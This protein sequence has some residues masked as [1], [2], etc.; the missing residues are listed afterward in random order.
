MAATITV[1]AGDNLQTAINAAQ[2][3]DTLLL[4]AGATFSGNFILPVK[5]GAAYITITTS[6][7]AGLPGPAARVLPAHAPWLAK[8][9]SPNNGP[10]L[11]TVPG[12]HHWRLVLL[13]FPATHLGYGDIMQIG[14]GSHA[15]NVLSMVPRDF[16]LDRLYVHGDPNVGQKRGIALNAASVTIRN[17]YISDIKA[18]GADTQA[19]GGWNGPGPYTIENNYLEASGELFLLGG[20]DPG[21][22][23]LVATGVVV[24]QNHFFRPMSWRDPILPDPAGVSVTAGAGGTLA[25]GTYTYQVVARKPVGGG[26]VARSAA[27]ATVAAAVGNG[28]SV[29]VRWNAVPGATQYYVYGRTGNSMTQYWTV[30]G[31]SFTDTGLAGQS[32]SVPTTAG[33]RWLV[34][35]L[36]QLKSARQVLVESNVF[37]NNWA[38]GQAGYAIVFTPRNQ[39]GNCTWCVISDVTFT[40][41]I[42]RNTAAAFNI[43]GYDDLAP[44]QQTTRITIIN[45]LVYGVRRSLGGNGW[46]VLMGA[47]PSHVVIDHNTVESDGSSLTYVSGGTAAA[48]QRVASFQFTNNAARHGDYGING[49]NFGYGNAIIAN[50]FPGGIIRGNWLQGGTAAR[51]PADNYFAGTF[52]DAFVDASGGN[53]AVSPGSILLG[54]ATDGGNIGADVPALMKSTRAALDGINV[55]RPP[56]PGNLRITVR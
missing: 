16:E 29:V 11:A 27:S 28:G 49:T 33:D 50:Y 5:T 51:Y 8:I 12:S 21:I 40:S 6:P 37:E 24:R 56:A 10:A 54:R 35:N 36:F 7:S 2:P 23:N 41:N 52:E 4:E 13:E 20:A 25:A 31:T 3:G 46:F 32:G 53:F 48:P 43:L 18:V 9:K 30:T 1:R 34:K 45:N 26:T 17:C 19:I 22:T 15:Q 47:S 44:S 14:D 42:V 39:D 55:P 38:H